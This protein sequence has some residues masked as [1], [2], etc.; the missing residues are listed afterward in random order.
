MQ[1]T[2]PPPPPP[3]PQFSPPVICQQ[4]QQ[5]QTIIIAERER[6]KVHL[7]GM[8]ISSQLKWQVSQSVTPSPSLITFLTELKDKRDNLI[9]PPLLMSIFRLLMLLSDWLTVWLL[10]GVI[11]L[12]SQWNK[13]VQ[14][15][16]DNGE[17]VCVCVCV[18]VCVFSHTWTWGHSAQHTA[19]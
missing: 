2:P 14:L 10:F 4:Q 11:E 16:A 7:N 12:K 15:S 19:N 13:K 18:C 1:M 9:T 17:A 3:A 6:E 8:D 5:Q